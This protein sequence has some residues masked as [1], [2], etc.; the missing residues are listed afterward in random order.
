MTQMETK[1]RGSGRNKRWSDR[2]VRANGNTKHGKS[3]ED[4][5]R[6]AEELKLFYMTVMTLLGPGQNRLAL[7]HSDS[8]SS[9]HW[10]TGATPAPAWRTKGRAVRRPAKCARRLPEVIGL[11]FISHDI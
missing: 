6:C 3:S 11:G 4:E 10:P 2:T 8:R 5:S 9:H 1:D 7:L